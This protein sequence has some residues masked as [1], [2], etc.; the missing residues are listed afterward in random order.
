MSVINFNVTPKFKKSFIEFNY[1]E[2][3]VNDKTIQVIRELVWRGGDIVVSIEENKLKEFNNVEEL[4]ETIKKNNV[5]I[6]DDNFPF[7]YEFDCSWDG[8]YDDYDISYTDGSEI[9]DE[10]EETILD[11]IINE[12]FYDLEDNH[13]YQMVDTKYEIDGDLIITKLI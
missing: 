5:I 6:F 7:E 10:T 3:K 1:L 4:F 12:S 13:G 8:C 9:S 2:K 11:I